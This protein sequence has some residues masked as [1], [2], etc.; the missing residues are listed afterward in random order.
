MFSRLVYAIFVGIFGAAIVHI[1]VLFLVPNYSN[2][3]AWTEIAEN[4]GMFDFTNLKPGG[5]LDTVLKRSDPLFISA[6]CRF[7]LSSGFVHVHAEGKVAYWS[8]AIFNRK[9][10]NIYSFNDRTAHRETLDLVVANPIQMVELRKDLPEEFAGSVFVETDMEQ[11][12]VVVRV[13]VPDQS[14][15]ELAQGFLDG[16]ECRTDGVRL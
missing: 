11:G 14:W 6:A 15:A 5:T 7:E 10:Q 16:A 13:F 2:Q 3:D 8:A 4:A 9:G 12:M 1:V